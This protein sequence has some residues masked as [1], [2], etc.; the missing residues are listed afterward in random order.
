MRIAVIFILVLLVSHRTF[1]QND[2]TLITSRE[3]VPLQAVADIQGIHILYTGQ[4]YTFNLVTSGDYDIR[5]TA[6]NAR[7]SI[8]E[9]SKKSTGGLRYKVIPVEPGECSILISNQINESRV[10]SL[11]KQVYFV[12]DCPMPPLYLNRIQSGQIINDLKDSVKIECHYP[13]EMGIDDNYTV[14]SW[15]VDVGDKSFS[16]TGNLLSSDLIKYCRVNNDELLHIKAVLRA[17]NT[18][19]TRSEGIFI[20]RLE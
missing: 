11:K 14:E 8:L 18:D 9:D 19:H 15:S 17:N 12:M 7:V 6:K 20:L 2:T 5:I 10:V 13:Q 16:G 1:A 4:E 3:N